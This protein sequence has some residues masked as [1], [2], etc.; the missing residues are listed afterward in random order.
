MKRYFFVVTA[1]LLT[2]AFFGATK[3]AQAAGCHFVSDDIG[4]VCEA[5]TDEATFVVPTPPE[6]SLY[7]DVNYARVNDLTN[8]YGAST[9]AGG[10]T[11]NLGDGYLWSTVT[12]PFTGDDGNMWY[13]MNQG[14]YIRAQD[15]RVYPISQ[16]AGVEVNNQPERPFGWMVVDYWYSDEPGAEPAEDAIKLPRYT[17]VEVYDAVKDDQD[18]IWYDI[19]NG[20]WMR[21]TYLS[22]IN[23]VDMPESLAE[24]EL[25]VDIDLYE[26]TFTAY[27]GRRMVYAG[28]I[29]S[30]LS[31]FGWDTDEGLFQVWDRWEETKMS[32]AEG[33]VD[34]YFIEDVPYTMY[35]DRVTEVALHGAYWH[36]R[37][38][39]KH[40]H[41]C[42]NMA[43]YQAEWVFNWSQDGDHEYFW[44]N[45]H[46]SNPDHHLNRID[47][48][49]TFSGA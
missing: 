46:T 4:Y 10:P 24:N 26:Q 21:Q 34:Y 20:R 28:L 48:I 31:Q 47:P 22:L 6:D 11:R 7:N 23:V 3:A 44:V 42:I 14:E 16:F 45:V 19:G 8:V 29:S 32:G 43:P 33:K 41:G 2:A 17:F 38:G 35:I 1:V 37:F 39:Y 36:D 12:G 15:A 49:E 27:E 9:M 18:W 40:S 30:G 13:L 5:D 25:W